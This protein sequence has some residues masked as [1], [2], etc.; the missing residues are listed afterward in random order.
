MHLWWIKCA[1]IVINLFVSMWSCLNIKSVLLDS[2]CS[3]RN[4]FSLSLCVAVVV[5]VSYLKTFETGMLTMLKRS[6]CGL[7]ATLSNPTGIVTVTKEKRLIIYKMFYYILINFN[8]RFISVLV[9]NF[10]LYL[11]RHTHRCSSATRVTWLTV[12]LPAC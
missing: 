4:T 2:K 6:W 3:L 9:F 5:F 8:N 1:T 7:Q 12:T 10:L 11:K